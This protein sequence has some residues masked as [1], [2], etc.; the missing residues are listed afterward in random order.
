MT[1]PTTDRPA[2]SP[3]DAA[4]PVV[5]VEDR[6][7][8]R[9]IT[10]NRPEAKN[11]IDAS[12]ARALADAVDGLE[13]DPSLSVGVLTGASGTFCAGFDLKAFLRGETAVIPGRGFGG[14]AEMVRRKPLV[15]AVEGWALAG[16][17][18]LVL[19][20]DLVVAAEDSRF[21]LPEAKRGLVAAGGGLVRLPR[22]MPYLIA[23][24]VGLTGEP[25][26]ATRAAQFGLINRLTPSGAALTEAIA[27]AEQIGANAPL[28][29][30]ATREIMAM[31]QDGSEVDAFAR[32]RSIVKP[33]FAS[34]DAAEGAL[35]FK[36]KRPPRWTGR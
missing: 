13:A 3:A 20:C 6:G 23:L 33:V 35:A 34:E 10:L 2:D 31:A 27:L 24:E 17:W 29:L 26:P 12:V 19:S 21:G 4:A 1:A 18:E 5:L 22:R 9:I 15:A 7:P 8:V 16:G 25:L 28:A 32:Q 11:A 30:Q 36:E 14:I